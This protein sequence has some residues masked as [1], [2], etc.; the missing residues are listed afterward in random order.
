MNTVLISLKSEFY[1]FK[2]SAILFGS[3]LFPVFIVGLFIWAIATHPYGDDAILKAGNN[4]GL[5]QWMQ[6]IGNIAAP[7][8]TFLVPMFT[9]YIA[10][11]VNEMEHKSDMWKSL[12]ALP[13]SKVG[14][15]IG[16]YLFAICLLFITMLCFYL[17]STISLHILSST[18]P[19]KFFYNQYSYGNRD[20]LLYFTKFFLSSLGILGLQMTFS[21]L[22]KDF[23]KPMGIGL[24]GVIVGSV[25]ATKKPETADYFPYAQPPRAALVQH[26]NVTNIKADLFDSFHMFSKDIIMSLI[27]LVVFS[28]IGFYIVSKKNIQ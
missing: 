14:I 12:F 13:L 2:K 1:K 3:I 28:I 18:N 11:S 17:L 15:Y 20:L 23:F 6:Y 9:I 5:Y 4:V 26:V 16:K 7:L 22:W 25:W 8:N 24:L 10:F 21:F 27:Y 19:K